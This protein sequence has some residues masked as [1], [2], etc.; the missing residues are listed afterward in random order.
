MLNDTGAAFA[1]AG[2][3]VADAASDIGNTIN[4]AKEEIIDKSGQAVGNILQFSKKL[5]YYLNII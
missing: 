3:A 2:A 5:K 1:E 4:D